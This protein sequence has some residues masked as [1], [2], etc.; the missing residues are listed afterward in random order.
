M[1]R[2]RSA[3]VKRDWDTLAS[4]VPNDAQRCFV[5][6]TTDPYQRIPARIFPLRGK[7]YAGLWE[8]EV[9]RGDRLYYLPD[10][11]SEPEM[12]GWSP[13][14]T[15]ES[16]ETIDNADETSRTERICLVFACGGHIT[17]PRR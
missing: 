8:Y 11:Q 9:N 16:E 6:L 13:N 12:A 3:R 7:V 10:A 17:P 14:D 15:G 2:G 5:H 1:V 4:R